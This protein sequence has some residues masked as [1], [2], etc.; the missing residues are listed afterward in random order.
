MTTENKSTERKHW[1]LAIIITLALAGGILAGSLFAKC[2][3]RERKTVKVERWTDTVVVT[4]TDTVVR[5]TVRWMPGRVDT[6]LAFGTDTLYIEGY[7]VDTVF[8]RDVELRLVT[9]DTVIH[10]TVK[11]TETIV[12][13]RSH[14]GFGVTAGVAGTYG[15]VNRKFDVGPAVAV[16]VI[17]KF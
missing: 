4:K 14:W 11:I 17:Y 5:D 16:G 3:T 15:I 8:L 10:D 7:A 9:H 2:G 6:L 1:A 12:K 13:K